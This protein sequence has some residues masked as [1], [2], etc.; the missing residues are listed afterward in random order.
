MQTKGFSVRKATAADE[1]AC[2]AVENACWP[3]FHLEAG[4]DEGY[5]HPDLHVVACDEQGAIVGT[6]DAVPLDWDG[7]P[8]RLPAGGWSEV[9]ERW[10]ARVRE[11]RLR[12]PASCACALGISVL[13]EWRARGVGFALLQALRAQAAASGYRRLLAP[14]RPSGKWRMPE[15]SYADYAQ[16]RLPDGRHVDPWLRLHERAGGRIVASCEESFR[17]T[18]SS[19]DWERLTGVRL[20][21]RGKL[22]LEGGNDY[23]LVQD[24]VGTMVEGS[25]WVVHELQEPA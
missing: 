25:I 6:G 9:V 17:M 8:A 2:W 24:G 3:R 18:H 14:V 1:A 16:V 10:L 13:P 5:Y 4:A 21:E 7:D 23:L 15:L 22:L 11:G 19:R 12:E 20:P